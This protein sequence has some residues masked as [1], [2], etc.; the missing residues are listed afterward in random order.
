MEFN[1]SREGIRVRVLD[2]IRRLLVTA[3][4]KALLYTRRGRQELPYRW[5][6]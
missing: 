5:I 3:P 1:S 4:H 6:F 2:Y